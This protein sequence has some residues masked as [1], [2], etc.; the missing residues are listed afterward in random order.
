MPLSLQVSFMVGSTAFTLWP[1]VNP[2]TLGP[3]PGE[4]QLAPLMESLGPEQLVQLLMAVVLE[5][6]VLLRVSIDSIII[7]IAALLAALFSASFTLSQL[8]I[9][10]KSR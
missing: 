2:V 9:P 10:G 4:L 1:A 5:R 6:R 3:P 7:G 8:E